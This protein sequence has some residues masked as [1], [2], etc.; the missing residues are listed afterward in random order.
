MPGILTAQRSHA[1]RIIK[2]PKGT[3][4]FHTHSDHGFLGTVEKEATFSNPK[5][6]SPNKGKVKKTEDHC[7]RI[8]SATDYPFSSQ[9]CGWTYFSSKRGY[10]EFSISE[11]QAWTAD[12][13]LCVT[14]R[15]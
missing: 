9:G 13:R 3:V 5:S 4:L 11:K 15:S 10:V 6:T 1:V 12:C 7:L 8:R 14:L 2:L